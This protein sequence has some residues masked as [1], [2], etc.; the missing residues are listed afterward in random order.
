MIR[1]IGK[2]SRPT[3]LRHALELC[4]DFAKTNHNRSVDN[5][6]DLIGL[7]DKFRIYKWIQSGAIP[8]NMIRPYEHACGC[9]FVTRYLA[10]SAH[11][12]LIDI[13]IGRKAADHDMHR[14]QTSFNE[15]VGALLAFSENKASAT[16]TIA[17]ITET[18]EELAWHRGNV[19]K[20]NQPE[21]DFM[22]DDHE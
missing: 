5:I 18:M 14:L 15:A 9:D 21:F 1:K 13:P 4:K 3:S 20:T 22:G 11:K 8:A 17:A 7:D 2:N 10:H 6:A 16:D 19:E 12:L